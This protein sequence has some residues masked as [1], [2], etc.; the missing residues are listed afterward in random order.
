MIKATIPFVKGFNEKIL[1]NVHLTQSGDSSTG[2]ARFRFKNFT[3]LER[4]KTNKKEIARMYLIN[5]EGGIE[6][7]TVIA[8][9]RNGKPDIYRMRSPTD[10]DRFMR[11]M[12]RYSEL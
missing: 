6:T 9:F 12:K 3:L 2:R 7:R 8:N 10:W 1:P 11:F 4:T 5:E